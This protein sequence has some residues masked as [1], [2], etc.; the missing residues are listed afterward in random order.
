MKDWFFFSTVSL[1]GSHEICLRTTFVAPRA[2]CYFWH[3]TCW[4]HW[5]SRPNHD[6]T[7]P[8]IFELRRWCAAEQALQQSCGSCS[9]SSG[10]T[11]SLPFVTRL[12]AFVSKVR[13][14]RLQL[15]FLWFTDFR[16]NHD[17]VSSSFFLHFLACCVEIRSRG[18]DNCKLTMLQNGNSLL[19][20]NNLSAS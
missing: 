18:A 19:C 9:P 12:L 6:I 16:R 13:F 17:L 10:I 3:A 2:T 15:S 20:N 14:I 5:E 8:K 11:V 1:Y 4:F 7:A